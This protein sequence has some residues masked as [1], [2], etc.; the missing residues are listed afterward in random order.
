MTSV[1]ITDNYRI[2]VASDN[3]GQTTTVTAPSPAATVTTTGLGPQGPG[4]T[5][6]LYG[7][8]IDI[9]DQPLI[10]TTTAQPLT[11]NTSL[12]TRGISVA[13]NS[14]ITFTAPGTYKILASLQ[15]TNT[16]N[17]IS[18]VNFFFAKN[19]TVITNSN[20]RIDLNS[21]KS[22]STPYHGCFTIEFQL[23]VAANDYL[24]LYWV[25]DTLGIT[26]DTIPAG[27]PH[28][29]A[30]SAIVNV[31][32]IMYLQTSVPNGTANGDT[33]IWNAAT[34]SWQASNSLTLLEQR[35]AA[36]ESV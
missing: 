7:S 18:E 10:S 15:V 29:Q 17:N 21:R 35:V 12:E 23:T 26:I 6:A 19:G 13:D 22:V 3:D 20:T 5:L 8:F 4:G 28:P 1:T 32:Q 2:V 25:A 33:L 34:S 24:Q 9:T 30:P 11:L 27:G 31:A 14:K 16:T 36:L